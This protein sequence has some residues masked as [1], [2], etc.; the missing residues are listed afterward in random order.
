MQ[1]TNDVLDILKQST[2]EV[3]LL[4]LPDVQLERALYE[5]VN[6]VLLNAGGKWN[7]KLKGHEF[8]SCPKEKLGL[9]IETGKIAGVV[10]AKKEFQAFYTPQSVAKRLVEIAGIKK[11]WNV[12]ESS[13][14][15]GAIALELRKAGAVV[16]CHEINPEAIKVL[17]SLGFATY[18]GDFLL[19]SPSDKLIDFDAVVINPPFRN[20]ADIKHV[21]HSFKF[22]KKG[23]VLVAIMSPHFTFAEDKASKNFNEWLEENNGGIVAEFPEGTF[24]ESGTNIRTYI[25]R[26]VKR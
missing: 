15:E 12:L 2:I 19:E 16:V 1:I 18:E 20:N 17:D 5:K 4:K 9:A 6:K 3:N 14:G 23:G 24:K 25:I 13:A 22:L 21:Q 8:K 10:E 11:D 26:I 7:R